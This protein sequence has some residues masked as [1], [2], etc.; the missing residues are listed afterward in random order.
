MGGGGGGTMM[1][2]VVV[3]V[4]VVDEEKK[5]KKQV[6][7]DD[8]HSMCAIKQNGWCHLELK[9]VSLLLNGVNHSL[10]SLS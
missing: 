7:E 9:L 8:V 6:K 2:V 5:G 3:V 4:V 10:F 1:M